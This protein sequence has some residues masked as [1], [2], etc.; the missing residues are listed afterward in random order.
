MVLDDRMSAELASELADSNRKL[1]KA[2]VDPRTIPVRF[3]RLRAMSRSALHYWQACQDDRKDTAAMK[4][5]RAA[6]AVVLGTGIAVWDGVTES[7]RAKPRNGKVWEAFKA[8]AA[9]K[10]ILN[11]KEFAH[12]QAIAHAI[13]R[14]KRMADMLYTGGTKLEHEIS[15][16]YIG[17]DCAS[18]LDA[19]RPGDFVADLKLVK[20]GQP[21]RFDRVALHS[22]YHA[23]MACYVEA[24]ERIG[25][26]TPDAFL[27]VVEHEPPFAATVRPLDAEVVEAGRRLFRLWFEKLLTHEAANDWP[28]YS[29]VDVPLCM[30]ADPLERFM[31]PPPDDE[32]DVAAA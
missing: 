24:A 4:L 22:F 23:Q 14:N 10:E 8:G 9:G 28:G 6:H 12:A 19:Y 32:D 11:A 29:D 31:P 1:V 17:R 15:W 25:D 5:G 26:P 3:S 30:P 21:A 16:K 7:G 2:P 27:L 13:T 20:D 18:H